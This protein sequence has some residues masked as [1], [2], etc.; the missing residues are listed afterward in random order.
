MGVEKK[1]RSLKKLDR[2]FII[3]VPPLNVVAIL[4]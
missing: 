2:L 1:K 3:Q 4:T